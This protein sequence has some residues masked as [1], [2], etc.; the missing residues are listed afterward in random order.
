[1]TTWK[2]VPARP[3]TRLALGCCV[4][5]GMRTETLTG[6]LQRMSANLA[7][8]QRQTDPVVEGL[9][10]RARRANWIAPFAGV[11]GMMVGMLGQGLVG[12]LWP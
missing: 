3:V 9:R 6:M 1:M 7:V 5:L 12:K 4:A 8:Y 2:L 11:G 10:L